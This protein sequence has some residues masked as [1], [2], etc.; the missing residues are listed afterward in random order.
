MTPALIGLGTLAVIAVRIMWRFAAK[1]TDAFGADDC[2]IAH[3]IAEGYDDA[4]MTPQ[5]RIYRYVKRQ[6]RTQQ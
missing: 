4:V 5:T 3:H 6:E 1:D 2:R